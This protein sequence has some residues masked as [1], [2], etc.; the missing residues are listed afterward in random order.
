MSAALLTTI[1]WITPATNQSY[2]EALVGGFVVKGDR[3]RTLPELKR[4]VGMRDQE[5]ARRA[6][7]EFHG[8][9]SFAVTPITFTAFALVVAIRRR[10]RL[11]SAVGTVGLTAFGYYIAM[12]LSLRFS[13]NA[14]L[15]TQ[16]SAWM[17]HVAL[18][19]TTVL[20]GLPYRVIVSR[21]RA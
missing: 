6:V 20:V 4:A 16:L 19:L 10:P 9:L 11:L 3:E 12:W 21:T 14:V 5:S 8:R 2:R 13:Q 1:G 7:I 15:P 18:L 17:P